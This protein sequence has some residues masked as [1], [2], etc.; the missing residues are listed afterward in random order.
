M[1]GVN[2]ADAAL[3]TLR[4]QVADIVLGTVSC[5]LERLRV[6]SQRSGGARAFAFSP[7]GESERDVGVQAL[8]QTPKFTPL[9]HTPL[10]CHALREDGCHVPAPGFRLVCLARAEPRQTQ[11]P[12]AM[13]NHRRV[14]NCSGRYRH[15][16]PRRPKRQMDAL[17]QPAGSLIMLVLLTVVLGPGFPGAWL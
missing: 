11:A 1:N 16:C 7:G 4:A 6:R 2:P 9:C 13:G 17:Q 15:V 12:P 3:A 10:I 14:G 8:V 5:P